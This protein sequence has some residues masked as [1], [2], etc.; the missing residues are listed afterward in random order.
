[1]SIKSFSHGSSGWFGSDVEEAFGS[2]LDWVIN[3][4]NGKSLFYL[5]I[6]P[7]E[8]ELYDRLLQETPPILRTF[9]EYWQDS[10]R[11]LAKLWH[12]NYLFA[13]EVD[14]YWNQKPSTRLHWGPSGGT[15]VVSVLADRIS[16]TPTEEAMRF[17]CLLITS[18]NWEKLAGPCIGCGAYYWR[19]T[20]RNI[21]Y[22]SRFCATRTTAIASTQK[23]RRDVHIDKLQRAKAA[24]GQWPNRRTK[25]S[26]KQWVSKREPD[27][28]VKFLTRAVN[29]GEL[30]PPIAN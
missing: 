1:M 26:W 12:D 8:Y 17:F 7:S 3:A 18:R 29:K 21:V 28:S 5:S 19:Q 16:R 22:C 4:L 11:N 30:K 13:L 27:I 6:E 23:K 25:L 20:A 14:R 9:V 24:A 2:E 10:G 15:S